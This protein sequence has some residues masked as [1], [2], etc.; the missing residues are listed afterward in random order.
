M[1]LKEAEVTFQITLSFRTFFLKH[2][3]PFAETQQQICKINMHVK[4]K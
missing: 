2:Q 1:R 3:N 4:Q